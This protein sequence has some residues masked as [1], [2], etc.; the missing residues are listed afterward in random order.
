MSN[1][2]IDKTKAVPPK[3]DVDTAQPKENPMSNTINTTTINN[4]TAQDNGPE[5]IK[6]MMQRIG[7]LAVTREVWEAT[8]YNRSNQALYKLIADCL[9]LYNDLTTGE[10][11]KHKKQGLKDYI[12]LKGYKFKETS[13]LSL[14]VIRCVF[15]DRDRRRLSTYHTVLR[16]AIA[17]KWAVVDVASKIGEYGGVQEISLGKKGGMSAKDK[18]N[19]A[20][21]A[22]MNQ[23]IATLSSDALIKQFKT[24]HIGENAVAVLTLNA[25]GT[26]SVHYVVRSTTAV[27]AALAGYFSQNKEVLKGLQEQQKAQD[28]EAEKTQAINNAVAAANESL[29]RKA[30]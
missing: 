16:V 24:E 19:A 28:A 22:L 9:A 1:T 17:D 14:K 21:A 8:E 26:Y 7:D 25:D 18:A 5:I 29:V 30:A 23:S 10:D 4:T 20:R 11:V 27:N 15:G 3:S 12:N 13:P 2:Y 6:S